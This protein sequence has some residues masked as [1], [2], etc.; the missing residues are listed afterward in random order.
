MSKPFTLTESL[1]CLMLLATIVFSKPGCSQGNADFVL[2]SNNQ[3][4]AR[5]EISA[6]ATPTEKYAAQ[7]LQSAIKKISGAELPIATQA[8]STGAARILIGTP[9]SFSATKAANLFTTK[10]EE[11][12]RIVRRD[13]VLYI[14]GLTPGAALRAVYT[15]LQ[16]TLGARWFWP[17][18]SG[19]YLPK[20]PTISIGSLDVRQ[21]PDI[22]IRSISIND[23]HF[24]PDTLVWM[25]RNR[26][27]LHNLQG[28]P[29]QIEPM[30]EKG[31]QVMIGGH[32]AY[33]ESEVLEKHPEYIA[34]INGKRQIMANP[35]HLCWSNA[36]AQQAMADKISKWWDDNPQIDSISFFGPDH[37]YFCECAMCKAYAPDSSTRWQKF[38]KAVISMVNKTHPRKNYQ[39]LAYQSYRDVPTEAA[40]F[41]LVGYTTYN[42]NYTKPLNDPTNAVAVGEIKAWQKAGGKMGLRGYQFIPFNAAMYA[43]ITGLIMDEVTWTKQNGLSGWTSEI[44]PYGYPKGLLPQEEYW[45]SNRMAVY[46]VAQAMWNSKLRPEDLIRDWTNHVYG[47]AAAPMLKYHTAM[48]TAWR[49]TDKQLSYFLQPPSGFVD[50]FLSDELL[51]SADADFR[52]ARQALN[53]IKD[54]T[55]KTRIST[56][57]DLEAAMF[58][59]WRQTFIYQQGRA[60][61]LQ[62]YAP[63]TATKPQLTGDIEEASWNDAF[64][65]PAFEIEKGAVPQEAT[66]VLAQWDIDALYLRFVNFDKDIAQLRNQRDGH[67]TDIFAEDEV[68]L[69]LDDPAHSG[70]Y[71]HLAAS[72]K[73]VRYDAKADGSMNF[74]A[75]WNPDWTAKT[76]ILADRW[77]LDVA[78]PFASFG[79]T[80]KEG[81]NW[82]MSFMRSGA[83]R[84]PNSG[85]PDA[86]V[87]NPAGFGTLTLVEKAPQQKRVVIY[88]AGGESNG[89]RTELARLGF[90]ASHVSQDETEL[91]TALGKGAEAIVFHASGAG[92]LLSEKFV[93]ENLQP[94]LRNGGLILVS[95]YG[96]WPFEKW[97][98]DEAAVKWSGWELDPTRHTTSHTDGDWIGKPH[99]LVDTVAG[100]YTPSSGF[101]PV[102]EGWEQLAKQ[103]MQNGEET[104]YLLRRKIGAGTL[105]LTSSDFGYGG[106]GEMFGSM[107]PASAAMLLNNFL[108][109]HQQH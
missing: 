81:L 27:N 74:D 4:V 97:F 42:I 39:T 32:N 6:T 73:G 17:G 109:E 70:H 12:T 50:S 3:P 44:I 29:S 18:E 93:T 63:R 34:E 68:E 90:Q 22:A 95:S 62:A 105:I 96:Q 33:L 76:S 52:A 43:P 107:N 57:I 47:P 10:I 64:K 35:P 91:A 89:L 98:G 56:Q 102:A 103:K 100:G 46:A 8:S 86:S 61:R 67:D 60:G 59:K 30:H 104:A 83:E 38:S 21:V 94:F 65:L 78:L 92:M 19:E 1:L 24:D 99:A 88:D 108:T 28:P 15:F 11:E 45:T 71:F 37:N 69:F 23:P 48:E 25:A 54:E 80:S 87:H 41:D 5:I 2:T 9:E 40:P 53:N 75:K 66:Q 51:K 31:F 72:A 20:Q 77:I 79:L 49:S 84:R 7:E 101:S 85:W 106:G 55:E 36:D 58:D 16:D 14:A 82:R 13:R 26:M